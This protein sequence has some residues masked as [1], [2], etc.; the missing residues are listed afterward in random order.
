MQCYAARS[1]ARQCFL[2]AFWRPAA[3][4]PPFLA[5]QIPLKPFDPTG[6]NTDSAK[7]I[8]DCRGEAC[9]ALLS[10]KEYFQGFRLKGTSAEM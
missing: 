4:S 1:N 7:S 5:K 10:D 8:I 2:A 6:S 3:K 9:L